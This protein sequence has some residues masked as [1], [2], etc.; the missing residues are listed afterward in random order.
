MIQRKIR[1]LLAVSHPRG[2]LFLVLLRFAVRA[3][4][5][6]VYLLNLLQGSVNLDLDMIA[7]RVALAGAIT[8]GPSR[9]AP[10][11]VATSSRS[12]SSWS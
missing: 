7:V 12:R 5:L 8:L 9:I 11:I 6:A 3:V 2:G 1:A 4:C 10:S